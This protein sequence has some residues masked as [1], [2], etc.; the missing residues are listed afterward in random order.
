MPAIITHHLFGEEAAGAIPE[1]I[2][3]GEEELLAF[4]LGNQG[5]DPYFSRFRDLPQACGACHQLAHRMHEENPYPTLAALREGVSHLRE[6]DKGVGRA[7][8]LGFLGHYVL[9]SYTH[10]FVYAQ[11]D[12]LI[13]ANPE[14]R[15]AHSETHAVIESDIDSWMLWSTRHTT[16][17]EQPAVNALAATPRIGLV[18]GALLSQV[19]YQG[20][21][22]QVS[23]EQYEGAVADYRFLYRHLDPAEERRPLATLVVGAERLFR[24]HSQIR[25][26]AHFA[27]VDEECPTLNLDRHHW[28]DPSTGEIS[29]ESF[30]DL[31]YEA[32]EVWRRSAEAVVRGDFATLREA[33]GNRNFNGVALG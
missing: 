1:G 14:L 26:M 20:F 29:H 33:T 31:F 13:A 8:A 7:F 12:A 11:E 17:V 23:P 16:V 22:L 9:D 5:P 10:P 19:A 2:V 6:D 28:V 18:A 30:P 32:L 21:G 15:D 4:L 25:A 3:G 24:D 27:Q